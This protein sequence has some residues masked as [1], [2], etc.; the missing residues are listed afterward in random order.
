M[1]VSFF[2]SP[3]PLA[4]TTLSIQL[5]I[6]ALRER[7]FNINVFRQQDEKERELK[8]PTG[9]MLFFQ[10][11]I[12]FGHGY[13]HVKHLKGKIP[14]IYIDDDF[15]GMNEDRHLSTLNQADLILVGNRQHANMMPSYVST[16]VE[17]FISIH[18]FE[19]Y[20]YLSPLDK[21]NPSPVISWQQSLA[22]VYIDDLLTVKDALLSLRQQYNI[23]LKLYG[24]HEGKDYNVP[25]RRQEILD[26]FPFAQCISFKPYEGYISSIVPDIR[27][28][29]IHIVPYANTI[30]R[31]G[32]SGFALKRT[33]C[34]GVPIVASS[35]GIHKELI[36]NGVNGFLIEKEKQWYTRIKTLIKNPSLR[37]TLSLNA[38]NYITSQ[39]SKERCTDIFIHAIQKH[40]PHFKP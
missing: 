9:D 33:M 16:P 13:E 20:P 31:I 4:P 36:T 12:G 23:E 28:T 40:F 38:H 21:S 29:D 39:Y 11:K 2:I 32:K 24:W 19:H 8:E 26:V 18:D 27:Q 6:Q 30:E 37:N 7:G 5:I 10:K 17:T 22:D 34:L 3:N 35:I 14:L 1:K 15:L 25:D